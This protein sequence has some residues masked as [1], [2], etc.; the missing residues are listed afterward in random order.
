[1]AQR[2]SDEKI[3]ENQTIH[4][5]LPDPVYTYL[6]IIYFKYLLIQLVFYTFKLGWFKTSVDYMYF[7]STNNYFNQ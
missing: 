3:N 6:N 2:K 1:V 4:G 7:E 5:S